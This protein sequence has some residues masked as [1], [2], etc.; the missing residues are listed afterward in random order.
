[1]CVLGSSRQEVSVDALMQRMRTLSQKQ[2]ECTETELN[3][4]FKTVEM[5]VSFEEKKINVLNVIAKLNFHI[6]GTRIT[7]HN[8]RANRRYTR[9]YQSFY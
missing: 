6:A 3:D 7:R 8:K 9:K 5:Q 4:R 2:D 1:M